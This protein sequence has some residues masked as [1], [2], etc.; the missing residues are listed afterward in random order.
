[1]ARIDERQSRVPDTVDIGAFD[2]ALELDATGAPLNP[3][4]FVNLDGVSSVDPRLLTEVAD[5]RRIVVGIATRPLPRALQPLLDSLTCTLVAESGADGRRSC[6]TVPDL[7]AAAAELEGAIGRSPRAALALA[8]VLRMTGGASVGAGLATESF[9]YSMLL[10][11]P[12]FARWRAGR[13][14]RPAQPPRDAVVIVERHGDVL[15]LTLNNP[16]RR[17]AFGRHLRDALC[18]AFDVA[19]LDESIA[20][21]ELA[22]AGPSFCSGGDLDE[23]GATRDV[24]AGHLIRLTRSVAGRIDRCRD[25][26]QVVVHGAC[27]GAGIELPSFAARIESHEDAFFQLPELAMGLIPGAGGTIGITRRIGRWRTAYL[28][29]TGARIGVD[30]ALAWGL[31]DAVV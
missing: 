28:A 15:R 19:V 3:A 23:F 1:M 4:S 27:I 13:P 2:A 20:R 29:L 26:T 6:V 5:S 25:R 14:V 10:A 21:I 12:E 22:G 24:G 18:D 11:G 8:D 17:N 30:T 7:A 9:A 31:V 16:Q